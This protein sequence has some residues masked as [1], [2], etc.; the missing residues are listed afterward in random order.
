MN[1]KEAAPAPKAEPPSGRL[2]PLEI[3]LQI[4]WS[5]AFALLVL[6]GFYWSWI[7]LL[8]PRAC[9]S[10]LGSSTIEEIPDRIWQAC[11]IIGP[12]SNVRLL[13]ALLLSAAA[14]TG[15]WVGGKITRQRGSWILA[16][17]FTYII[18]GLLSLTE[19]LFPFTGGLPISSTTMQAGLIATLL[20]GLP[21]ALG[22]Y[23]SRIVLGEADS[24]SP[25]ATQ[26]ELPHSLLGEVK[27]P[28]VIQD[29]P[30]QQL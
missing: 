17:L 6:I 15:I 16:L 18:L 2:N 29:G 4:F 24:A 23:F 13:L 3:S 8:N 11:V 12:Y 5:G 14:A 25:S 10:L 1:P 22:Y 27:S 7:Y 28:N 9:L 20:S 21:A 26:P 30:D 19:R